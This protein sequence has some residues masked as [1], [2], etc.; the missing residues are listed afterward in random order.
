MSI[1]T[2]SATKLSTLSYVILYVPD[3]KE[4]VT[5]YK[6][7]LGMTVKLDDEGWIELETGSV[8]LALHSSPDSTKSKERTT[9]VFSVEDV[10]EAYEG[11]K[12]SG[13]KFESELKEVC[14][15]PEHIGLSA[16]FFDPYG[17]RLSIFG[18]VDKK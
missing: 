3:A 9:A 8:T 13:V 16:D 1:E 15:T 11:L 7:K 17:N 4:A 10:K 6:E 12:K 18:M 5:F 14:A 2:K